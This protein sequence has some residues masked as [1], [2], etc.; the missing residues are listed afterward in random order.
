MWKPNPQ[1]S[2]W[3]QTCE[4]VDYAHMECICAQCVELDKRENDEGMRVSVSRLES[5][6]TTGGIR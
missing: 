6:A 4:E 5:G 1:L 2:Q 3:E